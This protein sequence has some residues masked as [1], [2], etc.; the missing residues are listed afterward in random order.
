MSIMAKLL[1]GHVCGA[2]LSSRCNSEPLQICYTS[3]DAKGGATL[4][5][6]VKV[7]IFIDMFLKSRQCNFCRRIELALKHFANL[8]MYFYNTPDIFF[9]HI[10]GRYREKNQPQ[11][12]RLHRFLSVPNS[13]CHFLFSYRMH[14]LGAIH[15]VS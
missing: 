10:P 3:R 4:N 6:I 11:S 15:E 8:F 9:L 5:F 13:L 14:K 2:L 12:A 7:P 1:A